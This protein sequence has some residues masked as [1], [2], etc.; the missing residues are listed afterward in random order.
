MSLTISPIPLA[1][2]APMMPWPRTKRPTPDQAC[3]KPAIGVRTPVA[4][5]SRAMAPSVACDELPGLFEGELGDAIEVEQRRQLL[6]EGVDEVDLPVEVQD[7]GAERLLFGLPGGEAFEQRG[8]GVGAGR[9]G[10]PPDV[11]VQVRHRHARAA[12]GGGVAVEQHALGVLDRDRRPERLGDLRDEG[13]RVALAPDDL[14]EDWW[15]AY[16]P[17]TS[18]A[19]CSS[20]SG[21]NGLVM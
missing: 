19:F 20:A 18:R 4:S 5:S 14:L 12:A 17:S 11:L 3:P 2:I 13:P 7:L 10:H 16:R 8:D 6:G 15:H 21:S 9:A 1:A